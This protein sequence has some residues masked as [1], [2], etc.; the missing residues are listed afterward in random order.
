MGE[1][2]KPAGA[3]RWNQ[4]GNEIFSK[5]AL[6][7]MRSPEKLDMTMS[8]TTPI[9]WMGLISVAV[10]ML[11]VV[12]WSIF[13]SFTVKA[14]G[15]GLIMDSSGLSKV[16]A[17]A[18][19]NMDEI[20][21]HPGDVV[22]KGELIA[23]VTMVQEEAATRM[24]RFGPRLASSSREAASRVHEFDSRRYQ[25]EAMEYIYSP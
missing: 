1:D 24:A 15:M 10:M 22:K 17:Q 6:D 25:Q 19:G 3:A 8:I 23:H 11:A 7:K 9:G 14:D 20:Y 16:Y 13:G 5:E 18:G 2:K 4:K 12:I 21:V